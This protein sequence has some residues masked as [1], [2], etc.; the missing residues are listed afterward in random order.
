MRF[1]K[2]NSHRELEAFVDICLIFHFLADQDPKTESTF[3]SKITQIRCKPGGL[4]D[5]DPKTESGFNPKNHAETLK[6][7]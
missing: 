3:S 2:L 7:R 5:K 6:T 4:E 1:P